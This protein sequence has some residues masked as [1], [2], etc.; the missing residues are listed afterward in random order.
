MKP[1][2]E[3]LIQFSEDPLAIVTTDTGYFKPGLPGRIIGGSQRE[4][5]LGPNG[6]SF[7]TIIPEF[8]VEILDVRRKFCE[9]GKDFVFVNQ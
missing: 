6:H 2:P 1:K 8:E 3:N 4:V 7:K 9:Y 5:Y